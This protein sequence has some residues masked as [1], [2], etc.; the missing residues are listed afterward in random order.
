MKL[1]GYLLD[2]YLIL[3]HYRWVQGV[4]LPLVNLFRRRFE[5]G[6]RLE[7]CQ[8]HWRSNGRLHHHG[9]PSQHNKVREQGAQLRLQ[10]QVTELWAASSGQPQLWHWCLHTGQNLQG[11]EINF[12][13]INY[14]FRRTIFLLVISIQ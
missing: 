13:S 4:P 12:R 9:L 1:N 3:R 14:F 10:P 2:R 5:Q 6:L 7:L 8:N 11:R